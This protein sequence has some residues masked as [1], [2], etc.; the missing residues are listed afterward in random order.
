LKRRFTG[1]NCF[2]LFTL[3]FVQFANPDPE[4]GFI[5]DFDMRRATAW[6][7]AALTPIELALNA[8]RMTPLQ[9]LREIRRLMRG[10][11]GDEARAVSG[12]LK[13]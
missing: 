3:W 6:I 11:K 9:D 1:P 13:S 5:H 4:H 2:I 8:R 7:F 12:R 10:G